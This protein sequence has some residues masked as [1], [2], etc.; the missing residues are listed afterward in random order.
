MGQKICQKIRQKIHQKIR[1]NI[2]SKKTSKN[3]IGTKNNSKT[4]EFLS[5][6]AQEKKRQ[7]R[8]I[9]SV[10][11]NSARPASGQRA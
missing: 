11:R 2:R 6:D 7:R 9:I 5:L 3:T 4:K 8:P 1:Q 10:L